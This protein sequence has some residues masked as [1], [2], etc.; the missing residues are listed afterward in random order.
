L[1]GEA[2]IGESARPAT[3]IV[4]HPTILDIPSCES[5]P[6]QGRAEVSRVLKIMAIAPES[7]MDIHDDDM[8]A[9]AFSEP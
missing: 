7:T 9:L 6:T 2:H 4:P 8:T 1:R 5:K 3:A